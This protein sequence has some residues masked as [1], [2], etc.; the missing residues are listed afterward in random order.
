MPDLP[1]VHDL[2]PADTWF[3][4]SFYIPNAGHSVHSLQTTLLLCLKPVG[5]DL[6]KVA[7]D[8]ETKQVSLMSS[9][10]YSRSVF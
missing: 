3:I 4:H 5:V 1:Y 9:P 8:Y 6:L 10:I 2:P 7:F